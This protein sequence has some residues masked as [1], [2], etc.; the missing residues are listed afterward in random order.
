MIR[1]R[2]SRQFAKF[3]LHHQ[4]RLGPQVDRDRPCCLQFSQA[5]LRDGDR[6]FLLFRARQTEYRLAGAYHLAGIGEHGGY[7]ARLIGHERAVA[8]LVAADLALRTRLFQSCP[9]AFE[10]II[11]GIEGGLAD[12]ALCQKVRIA[13]PLIAGGGEFAFRGANLGNCGLPCKPQIG[14]VEPGQS[15]SSLDAHA[16]IDEAGSNLSANPERQVNLVARP[17]I[18]G[19]DGIPDIAGACNLHQDLGNRW[20][21]PRAVAAAQDNGDIQGDG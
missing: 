14:R 7:H 17:H 5:A 10:G 18:A 3:P 9:S 12:E 2:R 1:I 21:R 11:L 16:A 20:R 19:I 15:L 8:G 4:I 13:R 6:D